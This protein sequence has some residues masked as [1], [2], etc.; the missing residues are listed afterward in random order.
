MVRQSF[1]SALLLMAARKAGVEQASFEACKEA[2]QLSLS[3]L[4]YWEQEA[5]DLRAS[6]L[7][8]EA[9]AKD[10]S[11]IEPQDATSPT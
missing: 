9:I 2:V 7:I 3:T 5:P 11:I 4:R 1:A 8:L 6:R 10:S